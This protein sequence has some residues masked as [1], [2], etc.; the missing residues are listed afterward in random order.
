[1]GLR[2]IINHCEIDQP[3]LDSDRLRHDVAV[4]DGSNRYRRN[5]RWA[6][7]GR[8]GC[9]CI[10]SG[11]ICAA[12]EEPERDQAQEEERS[13]WTLGVFGASLSHKHFCILLEEFLPLSL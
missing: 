6:G 9:T 4:I 12:R 13:V 7:G 11:G 8:P 3:R 2:A 10:G 5:G 1:M